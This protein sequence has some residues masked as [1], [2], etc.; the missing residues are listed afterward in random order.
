MDNTKL[1][2]SFNICNIPSITAIDFCHGLFTY[3]FKN[4]IRKFNIDELK[5]FIQM[6]FNNDNFKLIFI[7][8][9]PETVIEEGILYFENIGLVNRILNKNEIEIN[10]DKDTQAKI[11]KDIP[12][13]YS[14]YLKEIA[15]NYKYIMLKI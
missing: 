1:D 6:K 13:L 12:A 7:D 14:D 2:N 11:I 8:I 9:N 4:N 3:M 15:Y 10:I 5:K